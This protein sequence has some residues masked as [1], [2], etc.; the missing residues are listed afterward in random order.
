L[1][2]GIL[3]FLN[4]KS[5]N[6]GLIF[7]KIRQVPPYGDICFYHFDRAFYLFCRRFV[8]RSHGTQN[9]RFEISEWVWP[10]TKFAD[11]VAKLSQAGASVIAFDIGFLEPDNKQVVETIDAIQQDIKNLGARNPAIEKYL[12]KLKIEKENDRRL[13][14][15]IKTSRSKVVLGYFFQMDPANA[16]Y[17]TEEEIQI[18]QQNISN[19]MYNAER[20]SSREA[21]L[22]PLFEPVYP[23]SNI[24]EI[25]AA[26]LLSG[27][28]N[29]IPDTDGVVRWV[30]G[31]LKFRDTLYAPLSLASVSAFRNTPIEIMI[32]DYGVQEVSIGNLTIPTDEQGLTA[33]KKNHFPTYR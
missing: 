12:D 1:E 31:V 13:A 8:S 27:Y 4:F 21:R 7:K 14:Q 6:Y 9:H 33:V 29:M 19:S 32:D 22:F 2:Y 3:G 18:H 16:G 20:Y 25:S 30:P 17:I 15:A 23:Q 10:R 11:L 26:A 5:L 24:Q 28:F